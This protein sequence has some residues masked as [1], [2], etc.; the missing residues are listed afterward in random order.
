MTPPPPKI[1]TLIID[2]FPPF[3]AV[4]YTIMAAF[5][6]P[7]CRCA[8]GYIIIFQPPWWWREE[9]P[10]FPLFFSI[11]HVS[12]LYYF[13]DSAAAAAAFSS[14]ALFQYFEIWCADIFLYA[15]AAFS[16]LSCCFLFIFRQS[17]RWGY[18]FRYLY[19]YSAAFSLHIIM[20][21][22]RFTPPPFRFLFRRFSVYQQVTYYALW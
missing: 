10:P 6:S 3:F 8:D 17:C 20:P 22:R 11:F 14:F 5:P 19:Y 13:H 9:L 4:Y 21:R 2:I 1:L 15:A 16:P 18:D 12:P 7:C